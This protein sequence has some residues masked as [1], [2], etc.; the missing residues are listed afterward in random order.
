MTDSLRSGTAPTANQAS[1]F[2]PTFIFFSKRKKKMLEGKGQML[3]FQAVDFFRRDLRPWP[4]TA[5]QLMKIKVGLLVVKENLFRKIHYE[6]KT[7]A[8][9]HME[10]FSFRRSKRKPMCASSRC[11]F[12]SWHDLLFSF[13]LLVGLDHESLPTNEKKGKQK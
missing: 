7:S 9:R 2:L 13:F 10:S 8:V 4:P 11:S 12:P 1:L 6:N 3:I 5:N